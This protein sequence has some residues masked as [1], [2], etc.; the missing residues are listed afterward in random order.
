MVSDIRITT[1]YKRKR[2]KM[3][4]LIQ[5]SQEGHLEKEL[6]PTT[7]IQ[8]SEVK[9]TLDNTVK[10]QEFIGFGGAFTESTGYSLSFL[11]AKKQD[12]VYNAYFGSEGLGYT[13]CRTHINS[14]DFSLGNYAYVDDK[15]DKE[16]KTFNIARDRL[17]LIPMIKRAQKILEAQGHSLKLF[18]SPWSPPAFMKTNNLM[19]FGGKLRPEYRQ[20][21]ADYFVRYIKEY[22][23]EGINIWGLTVQ[24]EPEALQTWDSCLY[25]GTEERD[26]IRDYLGPALEKESLE[27]RIIL[28]DHNRDNVYDR[29]TIAYSDPKAS[30]YI[31]GAGIHIYMSE[32][33]ENT[34]LLHND[35]PDKHIVFTEGCCEGFKGDPKGSWENGE[36]YA[37]HI[38]GDLNNYVEAWCDW[39]LVL[40]ERG[41]PNHVE[42]YCSAPIIAHTKHNKV[43]YQNTYDYIGHFSRY[44]K[45]GATRIGH[46]ISEN[47]DIQIT[48]WQ[49]G[50]QTVVVLL[51]R[52]DCAKSYSLAINDNDAVNHEL[53]PHSI[54]TVLIDE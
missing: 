27:S 24:N 19:N 34:T 41:G 6:K 44:I 52:T 50:K 28:Y 40:D 35:F 51:N 10:Y 36:T 3:I 42:N 11:D 45:P 16:L 20:M 32:E 30:S 23:K 21:W 46:S 53:P 15:N 29:G 31:W 1:K 22:Q 26:F 39:N 5:T 18:A 14:C 49:T 17:Y 54:Q 48:T 47:T 37:Y 12:E 9:I 33:F 8:N 7:S 38:I 2:V 25:S 13:F 4:R 43:I